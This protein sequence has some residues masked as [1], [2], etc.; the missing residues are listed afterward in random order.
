GGN[1]GLGRSYGEYWSGGLSYGIQ[2]INV[3]GTTIPSSFSKGETRTGSVT[4]YGTRDT[5]DNYW[6]PRSGNK[7]NIS[8]EYAD[9][10]LGG[11]NIFTK[12]TLD[13]VWYYP[14][15]LDSAF[16]LHGRYAEGL[17]LRGHE[18]P[19]NEKFYVGGIYSVRGFDY[20]KASTPSTIDPVTKDLL[21]AD[22]E[23]IM[24]LE[25]VVPL[26]KEARINGVVFYDAGSGFGKQD[27][28][29]MSDLR[30]STGIGFR[31]LSPIGPL[32]LEWGYNLHPKPGERQGIWEFSIGSLF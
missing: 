19:A 3:S 29:T 27:S 28:I 16:M 7:N 30:T 31:W 14:M 4:V 5:R 20:G 11:D 6:D 22:K 15:M 18:F 9:S 26:V 8:V 32:R 13:T 1:V 24:N 10:F 21:G 17:G 2:T 25:Y 12:Y 23:L